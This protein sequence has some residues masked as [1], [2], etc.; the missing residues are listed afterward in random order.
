[1]QLLYKGDSR[2]V[3][4]IKKKTLRPGARYRL[5][6]F[7]CSYPA[8]GQIILRSSLSKQIY[9]LDTAEWEALNT[10]ALAE[11]DRNELAHARFLVEKEYDEFA[12]Y[13]M[14]FSALRSMDIP[15][16]GIS[17]YTIL[18]TTACNARCVYCYEEGIKPVNMTLKTADAV[19][20]FILRTKAEGAIRLSWFGGEPLLGAP[21]ISHICRALGEKSVE[22]SSSVTTNGT[23]LTPE[24]AQEA[25]ELWHLSNVQ[26]SMDGAR[27]DY[28]TR[29]NYSN[30]A[31]FNYDTAMKSI[32]LFSGTGAFVVIRCNY[33]NGNLPGMN[34]FFT[35]CRNRFGNAE[36]IRIYMA[37]LFQTVVGSGED[38]IYLNAADAENELG[39]TGLAL[40]GGLELRLRRHYCMADSSTDSVIIDPSGGL[41]FCE[42]FVDD[43]PIGSV[44]SDSTPSW[45]KQSSAVA[46]IC[47]DCCFLPDCTPFRRTGCPVKPADCKA[48]TSVKSEQLLRDFLRKIPAGGSGPIDFVED[49][50]PGEGSRRNDLC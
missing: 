35:D 46:D 9:A 13:M 49:E 12:Q 37:P 14:V 17:S 10:D 41:H 15:S 33:D 3:K 28:A 16:P 23:L 50:K 11:E 22:Y 48:T 38:N 21:I 2:V 1:M 44:F 4:I 42:H 40:D 7:V 30:P 27:S 34:E 47:K 31:R 29:K 43:D 26:V 45:P 39:K 5:S 6:R 19:V 18:P 24:M 8:D 36:N 32:E 25:K 20:D